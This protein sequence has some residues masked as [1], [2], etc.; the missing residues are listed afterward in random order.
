MDDPAQSQPGERKRQSKAPLIVGVGASAGAMDSIE[1]FFASLKPD[2][3]QAV[4]LVLRYR[5]AVEDARLRRALQRADGGRVAEISN[6]LAAAGGTIYVCPADMITTLRDGQF[7]LKPAE[8]GRG[9]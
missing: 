6:G 2:P 5:D 1:R 3:D 8:Q 7:C 9:E 4:V